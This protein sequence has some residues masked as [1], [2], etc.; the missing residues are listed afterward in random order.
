MRIRDI[1]ALIR[2]TEKAITK[3]NDMNKRY[4]RKYYN[5]AYEVCDNTITEWYSSYDP[6]MYNRR[7]SL[8]NMF[9]V[10][11]N[12]TKLLVDIDGEGLAGLD[13]YLYNLTFIR[14]YHGGADKGEGHPQYGIPYWR[15]PIPQFTQWGRPAQRNFSPYYR[16]K[17]R[18]DKRLTEVDK[19][20]QKEYDNI[21]SKIQKILNRF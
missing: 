21:V 7:G 10:R 5:T 18:L 13:E 14:G 2:A 3:V 6:I 8:Y 19:E 9:E 15:K 1:E 12:G 17:T 16:I 11:I 4:P 20:R